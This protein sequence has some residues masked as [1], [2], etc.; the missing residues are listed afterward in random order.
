MVLLT[1]AIFYYSIEHKKNYF[2]TYEE[3]AKEVFNKFKQ[4][5]GDK[6]CTDASYVTNLKFN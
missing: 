6:K 1:M 4:L 2:E 5:Y 3:D